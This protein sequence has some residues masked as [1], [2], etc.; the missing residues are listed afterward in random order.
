[1]EFGVAPD[2]VV[3]DLV[4]RIAHDDCIVADEH[5]TE[6]FIATSGSLTRE[7]EGL[8]HMCVA[9]KLVK[10]GSSHSCIV[11]FAD[12]VLVWNVE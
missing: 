11:V 3:R 9:T 4:V 1:M 8:A 10:F 12:K 6:R 5:G 7:L 2:I